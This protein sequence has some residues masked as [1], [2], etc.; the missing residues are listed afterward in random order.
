M[1]LIRTQKKKRLQDDEC[2]QLLLALDC[3]WL[4]RDESN[5]DLHRMASSIRSS[6]VIVNN[7]GCER[8][9]LDTYS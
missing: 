2:F 7:V 4:A 9:W 1:I 3:F 5:A 6:I 8:L